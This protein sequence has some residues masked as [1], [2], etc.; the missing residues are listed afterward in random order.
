MSALCQKRTLSRFSFDQLVGELLKMDRYI[1]AQFLGGLEVDNQL[2][3]CRI[4]HWKITG[5]FTLK[6]SIDICSGFSKEI[7]EIGSIGNQSAILC[8]IAEGT[9]KSGDVL[10]AGGESRRG[11]RLFRFRARSANTSRF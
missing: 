2:V 5:P 8:K 4:L 11:G 10:V 9:P 3:F 7:G 6:N 1:E